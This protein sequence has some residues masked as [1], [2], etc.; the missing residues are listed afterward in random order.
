MDTIE[1]PAGPVAE[2]LLVFEDIAGAVVTGKL[3]KG[4]GVLNIGGVTAERKG[5]C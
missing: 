1:H 4:T 3:V 2:P 5:E